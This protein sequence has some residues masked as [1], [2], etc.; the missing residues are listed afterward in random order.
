MDVSPYDKKNANG[1]NAAIE[2]ETSYST[3]NLSMITPITEVSRP[4]DI[5]SIT[6][7][8]TNNP[9]FFLCIIVVYSTSVTLAPREKLPAS[10]PLDFAYESTNNCTGKIL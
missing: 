8:K 10:K 3:W 5:Y 2:S 7:T 9:Y 1:S 4:N 6:V